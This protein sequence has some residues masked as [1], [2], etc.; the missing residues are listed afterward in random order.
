MALLGMRKKTMV[1]ALAGLA[2]S[3]CTRANPAF[4]G[5]DG[6]DGSG[7]ETTDDEGNTSAGPASGPDS[8]T[9]VDSNSGPGSATDVAT[10]GPVDDTGISTSHTSLDDTGD[11]DRDCGNGVKDPGEECDW[12]EQGL[13]GVCHAN[14]KLNDCGDGTKAAPEECDDGNNKPGDGCDPDCRKESACGDGILDPDVEE[15]EPNVGQLP[16]CASYG[17]EQ[18]AVTCNDECKYDP[19]GCHTCGDGILPSTPTPH[20]L[21]QHSHETVE[22][23]RCLPAS[24]SPPIPAAPAS[25]TTR[26]PA[27][28]LTPP[29]HLRGPHRRHAPPTDVASPRPVLAAPFT[30]HRQPVPILRSNRLVTAPYPG[31]KPRPGADRGQRGGRRS[32]RGAGESR[33]SRV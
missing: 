22:N 26:T 12:A 8:H 19:S 32:P 14:C 31:A 28:P 4:D 24:P 6:D 13:D 3:G 7:A 11:P 29:E 27:P 21:S 10:T 20:S 5:S 18:G 1:L 9:G 25:A 17:H 15:C 16:S 2:T 33:P 30:R 23:E